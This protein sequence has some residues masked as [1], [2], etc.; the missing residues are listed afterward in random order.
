MRRPFP[1]GRQTLRHDDTY[2]SDAGRDA[3]ALELADEYYYLNVLNELTENR[4]SAPS[5][6]LSLS[7][8]MSPAGYKRLTKGGSPTGCMLGDDR[9]T[10]MGTACA[11]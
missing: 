11:R 6:T 5:P 4:R 2:L 3:L 8:A 7:R 1:L 9:G 10:A